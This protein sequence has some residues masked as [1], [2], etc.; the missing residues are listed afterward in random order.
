MVRSFSEEKMKRS[1]IPVLAALLLTA[2]A[3][4]PVADVGLT[5]NE[6]V[7]ANC[8]K[9]GDV[10]ASDSLSPE[11]ARVA[12]SDAARSKGGNYV[13]MAN[14]AARTGTAYQCGM[15]KTASK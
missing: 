2:G 13:L 6:S 8:Q 9:V 1:P 12:L 15:P 7:V 3:C 14:D 11:A 10:T 4:T 5:T